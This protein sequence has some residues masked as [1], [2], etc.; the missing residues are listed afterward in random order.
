MR[1]Y[2][3]S[4]IQLEGAVYGR[5][6]FIKSWYRWWCQDDPPMNAI[7]IFSIDDVRK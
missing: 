7:R 3:D 1:V 6:A 4:D 2:Q 5:Q